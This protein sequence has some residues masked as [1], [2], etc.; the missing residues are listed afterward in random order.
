[1]TDSNTLEPLAAMKT[2][3][4]A[5]RRAAKWLAWLA[6]V[7]LVA[8][9]GAALVMA[10]IAPELHVTLGERSSAVQDLGPLDWVMTIGVLAVA[11]AIVLVV[12]PL[13]LAFALLATG[14]SLAV[15][16]VVVLA[17]LAWVTAPLWLAIALVAWLRRERRPSP[18]AAA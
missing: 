1:M 10:A 11:F 9:I 13:A 4:P 17:A 7:A 12:V 3:R 6:T 5:L 16:A 8:A 15:G 18:Q 14:A 2:R